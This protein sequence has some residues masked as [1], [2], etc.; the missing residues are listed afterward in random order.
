MYQIQQITND[1]LQRQTLILP[2]GSLVPITIYF[3]PLQQMWVIQ[4][5]VYDELTI[6][7]VS[8]TNNANILYQFKNQIPFGLLCASKST[9]E[10]S[11]IDDF[12]SGYSSLYLL[13][14]EEVTA[15]SEALSAREV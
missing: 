1:A 15:Y 7:S 8:I 11:L 12:S 13:T 9:R 10:P 6:R 5:L 3:M 4:E 2:D 14:E